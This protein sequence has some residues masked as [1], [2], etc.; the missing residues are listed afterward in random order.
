[1]PELTGK[2]RHVGTDNVNVIPVLSWHVV[3]EA[4]LSVVKWKVVENAVTCRTELGGIPWLN[5]AIGRCLWSIFSLSGALLNP[6]DGI[7]RHKTGCL[8]SRNG[9]QAIV[10]LRKRH[11]KVMENQNKV[12]GRW[13]VYLWKGKWHWCS[14]K[15]RILVLGLPRTSCM[16][17]KDI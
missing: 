4:Y 2:E 3:F 15:I 1:M 10:L 8:P 5:Q 13:L 7:K 9:M 16:N 12:S 17:L 11:N 14:R 6:L